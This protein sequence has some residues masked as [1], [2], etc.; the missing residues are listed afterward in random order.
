MKTAITVQ[1]TVSALIINNDISMS[2]GIAIFF[3]FP[4][5]K[6]KQTQRKIC[7]KNIKPRT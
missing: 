4:E 6:F 5:F 1:E 3:T 7:T 2:L